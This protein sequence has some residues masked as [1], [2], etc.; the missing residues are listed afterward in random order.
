MHFPPTAPEGFSGR[1]K[2]SAMNSAMPLAIIVGFS[3]SGAARGSAPA[4]APFLM[5]P[6][7]KGEQLV[8]GLKHE[9]PSALAFD[10]RNRPYLF[11]TRELESFGY[12]L[13]LRGGKWVRLSYL[14]ALK[15]IHP[16]LQKPA[17]RFL[18]A[19]GT[20]TIDD[21]DGL[22]AIL[23]VRTDAQRSGWALLYSPDLAGSFQ[24][25]D[26]PCQAFLETRSGHNDLSAPP[27][28]GLLKFRKSHPAQWTAYHELSVT[29]PVKKA[30]RLELPAPVP[31]TA[32]CFGISNHSGGYSF[33]VTTG[34][35]THLVYAEIPPDGKGNPTYAATYDRRTRKIAAK[36]LLCLAPPKT[37]DVHSTPV[38]AAD[39]RRHLHV[40][41]GAHGQ[42]FLYL[43]SLKP[44]RIDAGWS[45]AKP[46]GR[47]QTYATL[48]CDDNDRLHTFFR[49][50]KSGATLS[51][52]HKP[53]RADAWGPSLT[54]V[55]APLKQR[56]YGI[57]YHRAWFDRA[58]AIYVSF[59][60]NAQ[61]GGVYPRALIVSEDGG[62]TWRLATTETFV[63][64]LRQAKAAAATHR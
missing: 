32:D 44:D 27:A 47:R 23:L 21:A 51:V 62:K 56:G 36:K 45:E 55:N 31:V 54:L 6:T 10:K 40:I 16:K 11:H 41:A 9:A 58:G 39:A 5:P 24:A 12:I 13:T 60:F 48:L 46:V 17:K 7:G 33:A 3:L 50:W 49:E 15:R 59:T 30:G 38:I 34:R 61:K 4:G 25:H 1:M 37:V 29:V 53:A 42:S 2:G 63:R 18:H 43:R 35:R 26:L 52:Q 19:L 20:M 64:R 57:F 28:I 14:A 8:G 22:Y